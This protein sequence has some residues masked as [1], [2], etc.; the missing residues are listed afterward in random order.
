MVIEYDEGVAVLDT[1][2]T[3]VPGARYEQVTVVVVGGA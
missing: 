1:T 3:L 2:L